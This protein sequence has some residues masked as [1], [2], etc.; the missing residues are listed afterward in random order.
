MIRVIS[1]RRRERLA[2][3]WRRAASGIGGDGS[4]PASTACRTASGETRSRRAAV[5]RVY[6]SMPPD[7]HVGPRSASEIFR[8]C[9]GKESIFLDFLATRPVAAR[10]GPGPSLEPSGRARGAPRPSAAPI[11]ARAVPPPAPPR[12]RR[13]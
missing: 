3:C 7:Y 1:V 8:L 2:A 13:R 11:R 4:A 12:Q 5:E 9:S 6:V 10:A